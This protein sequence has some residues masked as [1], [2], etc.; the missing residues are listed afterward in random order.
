MVMA[1]L[2]APH[3][4]GIAFHQEL[5]RRGILV[6]LVLV[7]GETLEPSAL[8][9]LAQTGCPLLSKPFRLKDLRRVLEEALIH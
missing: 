9:L 5:G 6:P 7:T 2:R 4:E 3:V 1:D 8:E